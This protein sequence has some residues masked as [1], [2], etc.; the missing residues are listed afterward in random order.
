MYV[1]H[2]LFIHMLSE[3]HNYAASLLVMKIIY[4][5]CMQ[6][7]SCVNNCYVNNICSMFVGYRKYYMQLESYVCNYNVNNIRSLFAMNTTVM[8]SVRY[9]KVL[10]KQFMQLVS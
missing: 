4:E 6:F 9:I 2:E 5:E 8:R 10:C 1:A 3:Q 7:V